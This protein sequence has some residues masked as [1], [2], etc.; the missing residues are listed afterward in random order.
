MNGGTKEEREVGEG[1]GEGEEEEY[2][3]GVGGGDE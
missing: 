1:T 3:G 2:A